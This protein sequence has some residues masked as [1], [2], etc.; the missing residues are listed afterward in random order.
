MPTGIPWTEF[1]KGQAIAYR[2]DGKTIRAIADILKIGKSEI[3]EILKNPDPEA[4]GK[5]KNLED[6][7][8]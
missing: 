8:K 2:N 4:Q 5:R 1:Q 6:P 3:A 7:K